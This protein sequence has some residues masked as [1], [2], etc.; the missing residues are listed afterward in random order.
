MLA[1]RYIKCTKLLAKCHFWP[2]I[3]V[4]YIPAVSSVSPLLSGL[5]QVISAV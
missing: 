3:P 1:G 2:V 5:L 4:M